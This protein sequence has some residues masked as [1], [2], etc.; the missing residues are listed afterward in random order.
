[1]HGSMAILRGV[2]SGFSIARAPKQG[3]L[4]VSDNRGRVLAERT[5]SSTPFVTLVAPVPVQHATTIYARFGDWFGW[6]NGA[7][8][9]LLVVSAFR[10]T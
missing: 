8:L 1:M 3:V 5:S 6:L 7:L 2:E 9:L 4:S 10:K